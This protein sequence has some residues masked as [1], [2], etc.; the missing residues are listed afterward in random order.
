[1]SGTTGKLAVRS[2]GLGYSGAVHEEKLRAE[3]W[4]GRT[5]AE[6]GG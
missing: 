5:A 6:G 2:Q 3:R 4:M 1:M